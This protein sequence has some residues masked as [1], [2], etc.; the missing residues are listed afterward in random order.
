VDLKAL[1]QVREPPCVSV[2][3]PTH[4]RRPEARSDAIAYRNLC[5]EAEKILERDVAGPVARK[6]VE[7]LQSIDRQ[8]FWDEGRLSDGLA[9]FASSGFLGAYRLPGR[10]STPSR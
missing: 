4:R 1:L 10:P 7:R 9:V 5:R 2:Y 3:L 6:L 8:E